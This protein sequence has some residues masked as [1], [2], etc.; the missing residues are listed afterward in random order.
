[1]KS[2]FLNR[3]TNLKEMCS[4]P[5]VDLVVSGEAGTGDKGVQVEKTVKPM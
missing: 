5:Q 1:M 2:G 3:Q 4:G